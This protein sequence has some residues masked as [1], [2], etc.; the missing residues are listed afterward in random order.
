MYNFQLYNNWADAAMR[1]GLELKSKDGRAIYMEDPTTGT[2]IGKEGNGEQQFFFMLWTPLNKLG[3]V[4]N[5]LPNWQMALHTLKDNHSDFHIEAAKYHCNDESHYAWFPEINLKR[6]S[7]I[8]V[9]DII[10][11]VKRIRDFDNHAKWQ[12]FAS[13]ATLSEETA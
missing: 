6:N 4:F 7:D 5:D 8:T 3:S 12:T 10:K 13:L 1:L 2:T 11:C 9:D